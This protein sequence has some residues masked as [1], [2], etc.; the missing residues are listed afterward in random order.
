MA[1]GDVVITTD[2]WFPGHQD[3]VGREPSTKGAGRHRDA[4]PTRY[5]VWVDAGRGPDYAYPELTPR[6]ALH[7]VACRNGCGRPGMIAGS[8]HPTREGAS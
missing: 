7:L 1:T 8:P 2:L 4:D 3:P 6:T 5:I